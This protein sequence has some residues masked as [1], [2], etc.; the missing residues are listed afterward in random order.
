MVGATPVLVDV[1]ED[2]FCMD[3][4]KLEQA[5]TSKTK[6]IIPVHLYGQAADIDEI[7]EI[8]K[9]HSLIVIE[10]A[11]QAIAAEYKGNKAGNLGDLGC[12]SLYAT[13]NIMSG[14]GGMITTNND[15]YAA[16]IR[17]FRQ[18]G[19]SAPYM[20]DELGY[21]YRLTDL[22]AAI[23]VEQLKKADKFTEARQHNAS[24][25]NE[26]LGGI[27]GLII[28]SVGEDRTHVYHQY[29]VRITD[30]FATARDEFVAALRERGV[31][32][33]VYYPRALHTYPHIAKLGFSIGD[34]PVSEQVASQVVSLPVHPAVS[35]E[36]LR[37]IIADIKEIA[38]V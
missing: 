5:I 17:S 2:T 7:N 19:M 33:G 16:A 6:A 25:L 29:T 23:G 14:E 9:K 20:Y 21:N 26:G 18:H 35:E 32:A 27:A 10:D 15:D 36:D 11:C 34:F 12:F 13:K 37:K 24:V 8:A 31:G 38:N 28:P 1:N 3:V 4:S 22:Q 30:D